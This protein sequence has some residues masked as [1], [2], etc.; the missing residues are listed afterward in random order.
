MT[1]TSSRSSIKSNLG[2]SGHANMDLWSKMNGPF[3]SNSTFPHMCRRRHQRICPCTCH[4]VYCWRSRVPFGLF[5]NHTGSPFPADVALSLPRC[6]KGAARP[7][8]HGPPRVLRRQ[9]L[10]LRAPA[11][12]LSN[13]HDMK[14]VR[15]C[16]VRHVGG[17]RSCYPPKVGVL[18][19]LCAS[20]RALAGRAHGTP[21]TYMYWCPCWGL[22]FFVLARSGLLP[23]ARKLLVL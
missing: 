5:G 12:L 17:R 1:P 20:T 10:K 7:V 8:L 22:T 3:E 21:T 16:A 6:N 15:S 19:C 4:R 18:L 9:L 11:G 2:E 14:P 13:A 23:L